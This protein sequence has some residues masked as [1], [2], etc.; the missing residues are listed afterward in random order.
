MNCWAS[1]GIEVTMT[2]EMFA[3]FADIFPDKKLPK[4]YDLHFGPMEKFLKNLIVD[5]SFLKNDLP[6]IVDYIDKDADSNS[7][8][9]WNLVYGFEAAREESFSGLSPRV[10][11][12]LDAAAHMRVGFYSQNMQKLKRQFL[13]ILKNH[14][15]NLQKL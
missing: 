13:Q 4:Y 12:F 9:I 2:N 6:V 11:S 3:A 8:L 1:P 14:N 7:Q 10:V 5:E 15:N